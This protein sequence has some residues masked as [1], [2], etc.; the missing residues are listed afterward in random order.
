MIIPFVDF[1]R[2]NQEIGK[3]TLTA[4]KRVLKSGRFVLGDETQKFEEEFSR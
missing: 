3:Q 1:S 2:E 4:V